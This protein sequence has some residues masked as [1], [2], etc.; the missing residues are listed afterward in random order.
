VRCQQSHIAWTIGSQMLVKF[1]ALRAGRV[2]PQETS[3]G[4]QGHGAAER[5]R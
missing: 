2:L 3:S 5:I 1:P 4:S